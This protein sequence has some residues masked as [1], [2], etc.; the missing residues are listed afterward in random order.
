MDEGAWISAACTTALEGAVPEHRLLV[1]PRILCNNNQACCP[2]DWWRNLPD[3]SLVSPI[4][5]CVCQEYSFT[6][7]VAHGTA[8]YTWT[9]SSVPEGLVFDSATGTLSGIPLFAD[10]YQFTITVSDLFGRTDERD[11]SLLVGANDSDECGIAIDSVAETAFDATYVTI[12]WNSPTFPYMDDS[13]YRIFRNGELL[14]QQSVLGARSFTDTTI[15]S[16]QN[17][18]YLVNFYHG[19]ECPFTDETVPAI[20][21][22][23]GAAVLDSEGFAILES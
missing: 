21:D 8:P 23:T 14:H 13:F 6:F 9:I 7:Q 16:G 15:E 5:A 1:M 4:D 20:L 19:S 11:Y 10:T 22:T 18:E 3:L 12:S 17:Y 2:R